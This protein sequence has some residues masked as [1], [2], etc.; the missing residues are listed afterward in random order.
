VITY[1]EAVDIF[2]TKQEPKWDGPGTFYVEMDG[3]ENEDFYLIP[4]G[5]R[6]YILDDDPLFEVTDLP[7][8]LV[9]KTTGEV[10]FRDYLPN[11]EFFL[12]FT[13]V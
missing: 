4:Y 11:I 8:G 1:Q 3:Y 13:Q 6:E 10:S 7:T 9:N 12:K 5:P 2:T